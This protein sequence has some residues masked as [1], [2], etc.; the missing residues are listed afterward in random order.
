MRRET[1]KNRRV[2][3]SRIGSAAPWGFLLLSVK[4]V[5]SVSVVLT[6]L[7]G[8]SNDL[9]GSALAAP[10]PS[11]AERSVFLD[12]GHSGLS[13][14]S[15]TRQ[16]PN[17]RGGTK[18]CQTTGTSTGSGYPEHAFNWDVVNR[19]RTRLEAQGVRVQLSR[20]NDTELG[21]CIDQRADD[22]NAM[23]PDAI[24]SIHAD[25]GPDWGRGFHV[26]YSSPPLNDTQ[27]GTSVGFAQLMRD[28]LRSKGLQ[29]ANYIGSG[30]L[31]GRAD[32]AGLNLYQYPGILVE[33]GNMR[34]VD[35]AAE[36]ESAEGRETYAVAVTD[37]ISAFLQT[38]G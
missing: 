10:A 28:T 14:A 25:G 13:D 21:P 19:I 32:L 11:Q 1:A 24:V 27:A 30:G 33:L 22:A 23:K 3:L 9:S 36:M 15:I 8:C 17:G 35:E 37:G 2:T 38:I 31:I 5:L 16:V 4:H 12:P 20:P 29:E 34:N 6:V 7:V 18:D 26:I